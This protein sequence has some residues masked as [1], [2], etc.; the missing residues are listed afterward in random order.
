MPAHPKNHIRSPKTDSG[1][2]LRRYDNRTFAVF[3]KIGPDNPAIRG[4]ACYQRDDSLG[5]ILRIH[6]SEHPLGEPD[7]IVVESEWNGL[8]Y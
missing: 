7:I 5:N 4:K 1:R 3:L 8:Y 6:I 2:S